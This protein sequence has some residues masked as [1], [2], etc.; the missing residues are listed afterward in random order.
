MKFKNIVSTTL[1]A[2]C[3]LLTSVFNACKKDNNEFVLNKPDLEFYVLSASNQITLY[4]SSNVATPVRASV[5]IGNMQAAAGT[6]P[7]ETVLAIDFRPATGQLYAVTSNSRLL[8]INPVSGASTPVGTLSPALDGTVVGFDFNP[9]VDR[10]RIVSSAGQNLRVNPENASVTTDGS[11]NGGTTPAISSSAYTNNTSGST[12]TTLYDI[13]VVARKLYKQDPP[14]AGTLVEVGSLNIPESSGNSGFDIA[15]NGVALAVIRNAGNSALFQ[16]NLETGAAT[17]LGSISNSSASA[18]PYI[19]LAIVPRPV[20]YAV[21]ESNNLMTFDPTNTTTTAPI[22]KPITGLQAGESILGIDFRPS[23][24]QLYALGST[25]RI[26]TINTAS[27]AATDVSI[28]PF[29]PLLSGT[30]FGFDF[31]PLDNAI[32]V[33]SNTGQNLRINPATGTV[34]GVD[35]VIN[36][37]NLITAAA[38]TGIT[39]TGTSQSTTL[40][41]IDNTADKLYTQNQTTGVLTSVG[42]AN[43]KLGVDVDASNGFDIG[44]SSGTAYGLFTVTTK[45]NNVDTVSYRLFSINLSNGAATAVVDFPKAVRG[46]ALGL[47]F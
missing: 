25:S 5:S 45:V 46:F 38:F 19:G 41:I 26:Y 10:I 18:S 33:V 16:I 1:L 13:D 30:S 6:V 23:N 43:L 32:R 21:D 17:T 20:A 44:A 37:A 14:N 3:V 40:Y 12:S 34:S 35:P 8:V 22:S 29:I 15:P 28:T 11:I 47:G 39:G 9:T 31:N 36:S 7:A 2:G 42:A 27:G 24:S 4:N